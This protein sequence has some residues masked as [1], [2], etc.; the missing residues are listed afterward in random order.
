M[1]PE[2]LPLFMIGDTHNDKP[3]PYYW[4][5]LQAMLEQRDLIKSIP[6]PVAGTVETRSWRKT[7]LCT[8]LPE[9]QASYLIQRADF[10]VRDTSMG[11][12]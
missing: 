8:P 7:Q 3:D 11:I 1:Q 10:L 6:V 5:R 4:E 9:Q 12:K 2:F